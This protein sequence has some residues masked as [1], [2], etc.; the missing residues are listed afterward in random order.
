MSMATGSAQ[1]ATQD[2]RKIVSMGREPQFGDQPGNDQLLE[3][4]LALSAEVSVLRDRLDV[5]ERLAQGG[6]APTQEAVD[7]FKPSPEV[8]AYRSK[9]RTAFLAK[10][11]RPIRQAAARDLLAR[12]DARTIAAE[13]AAE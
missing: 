13:Q 12:Q 11:F 6:E 8:S 9:R 5:H 10:L 3:M 4:V 7:A 2:L 1:T